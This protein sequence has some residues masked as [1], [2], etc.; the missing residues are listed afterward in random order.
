VDGSD[1]A[2]ADT[3]FIA[4]E[5]R[6]FVPRDG[7]VAYLDVG[8]EKEISLGPT[9]RFE[10]LGWHSSK[11]AVKESQSGSPAA[12]DQ[13]VKEESSRGNGGNTPC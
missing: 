1:L 11:F 3:D 7:L 6:T 9:T 2:D 10:N 12:D 8:W 5:P 13:T 4:T